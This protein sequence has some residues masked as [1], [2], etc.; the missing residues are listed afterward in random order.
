MTPSLFTSAALLAGVELKHLN[1]DDSRT[2][3]LLEVTEI[4]LSVE[5]L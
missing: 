4:I 2:A 1:W 3:C 5:F